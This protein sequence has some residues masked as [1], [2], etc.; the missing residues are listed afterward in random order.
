MISTLIR[1]LLILVFC[2]A[3]VALF[4]QTKQR[5]VVK[6]LNSNQKTLTDV[7][8]TFHNAESVR[9]DKNGNFE[10]L[11]KDKKYGE[12][13]VYDKI[14]KKG[15][16]IV[17]LK[18][19]EVVKLNKGK[20]TIILCPKGQIMQNKAK[21][22]ALSTKAITTSYERKISQLE[23]QFEKGKISK[24]IFSLKQDEL[25]SQKQNILEYADELSE[26]F[27]RTNFDDVSNLYKKAFEQFKK[28]KIE[29]AIEILETANQNSTDKNK[30][31]SSDIWTIKLSAQM[32]MMT[33]QYKKADDTYHA[34]W[35]ID[36]TNIQN[37]TSYASFL[38]QRKQYKKSL[39]FYKKLL[40]LDIEGRRR[41]DTYRT[42]GLIYQD[43]KKLS[44]ALEYYKKYND[45]YEKL[46]KIER[47]NTFYNKHLSMA[48]L[49]LGLIYQEQGSFDHAE[50]AF[51]R[52][53]ELLEELQQENP[54]NLEYK[55]SLAACYESIG[56]FYI[57]KGDFVQA[58]EFLYLDYKLMME[59]YQN[60]SQN[61]H[62][63][64]NLILTCQSLGFVYDEQGEFAKAKELYLHANQLSQELY[65]SEP[66]NENFESL[67]A[68]SYGSLASSYHNEAN[69][70]KA[71]DMFVLSIDLLEKLVEK[72][73]QD[74]DNKSILGGAYGLLGLVYFDKA[75]VNKAEE[76]LSLG[77]NLLKKSYKSNSQS[78][79]FKIQFGFMQQS[80][81]GIYLEQHKYKEAKELYI[82][83][84]ALFEELYKKNTQNYRSYMGMGMSYM[85]L[86][87]VYIELE[88]NKEGFDY[89]K[90]AYEIFENLFGITQNQ[91]YK[92]LADALKIE[93]EN[94]DK[95]KAQQIV[96]DL[97]RI[98]ELKKEKQSKEIK[99]E[100]SLRYGNLSWH[101]L[102]EKKFAESEKAALDALKYDDSQH[103]VET[104][105]IHSYLFRGNY[106]KAKK[107]YLEVK[108]KRFT[109]NFEYQTYGD[110]FL[111]DLKELEEAGVTHKDVAKIRA[112]LKAK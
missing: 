104:N 32:Y 74:E 4:A 71:E 21:Y 8:I 101:Y 94:S 55:N 110:V 63:K 86:G 18:E 112:L 36:T 70:E 48:K 60:Q 102:F 75:D 65:Q 99:T 82:N 49:A 22:Y 79:Q 109:D 42:I 7:Q 66:Q 68:S 14:Y 51:I 96:M 92:T 64:E 27:A 5:G 62:Y 59:V 15:Y 20:L 33:F 108:D 47:H 30:I 35:K 2:F 103:W 95:T 87:I 93:I 84:V 77:V 29:K 24:D 37:T 54:Q 83:G 23:K 57:A 61:Q 41:G 9:S 39:L 72:F 50:K 81:A 6:I 28:G 85:Q 80:L 17:N 91:Y 88:D 73:P 19:I 52:S 98:K 11:F 56:G 34:L 44:Q 10:I 76:F 106:E 3:N 25:L 100:I 31:S 107:M 53:K 97:N 43:I 12:V 45:M 46:Y 78:Q 40:Q 69:L 26:Q 58:E 89:Y 16:E 13:I 90:K 38:E 1:H 105:L 67:L 111:A